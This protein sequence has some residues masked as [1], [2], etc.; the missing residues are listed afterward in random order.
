MEIEIGG[1]RQVAGSDNEVTDRKGG[2]CDL[3]QYKIMLVDDEPDLLDLLEKALNIEGY[4]NIIKIDNGTMAVEA[5]REIRPD[6]IILDVMLP[7]SAGWSP[8]RRVRRSFPEGPWS[9]P[10]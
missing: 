5:S 8:L 3:V 10:G 2:C 6:I 9:F 1:D 7:R 4:Q